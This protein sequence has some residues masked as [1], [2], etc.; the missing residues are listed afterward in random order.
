MKK[1]IIRCLLFSIPLWIYA[2]FIALIDP[3][4]Y[5]NS[6]TVINLKD[7]KEI[8]EAL[9]IR[10]W[11]IINYNHKQSKNI[12]LGDSRAN[13]PIDYFEQQT[14][15]EFYNFAVFAVTIDEISDAFWY[16]AKQTKLE[17]AY[18]GI[19]FNHFNK[20]NNKNLLTG[21]IQK[22]NPT[23]YI[24]ESANFEGAYTI[25]ASRIKGEIIKKGKPNMSREQFW[26]SQLKEEAKKY[27][28][29]YKYPDNYFEKLKKIADYCQKNNIKLIFFSPP[30]HT[31]LQ[32][33]INQY[34]LQ[35]EF[36]RFKQDMKKLGTW[37]DFD[38]PNE[39]TKNADNFDDPFHLKTSMRYKVITDDLL[40][41]Q[42]KYSVRYIKKEAK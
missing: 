41:E 9:D 27:Y 26:Q 28:S 38:Y 36:E 33:T 31:D 8:S 22:N 29:L 5:F 25:I 35:K 34:N 24:L 23:S 16:V 30:T 42:G 39:L 4:N 3:F 1:F 13:F 17:S 18:I 32:N 40:N 2:G 37:V 7:K 12:I 15:K 21:K 14:G 19:S 10:Y 11:R 20:Y 6:T